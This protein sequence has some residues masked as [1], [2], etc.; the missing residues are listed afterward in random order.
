V[1][2]LSD[3]CPEAHI[4]AII[5]PKKSYRDS[6]AWNWLTSLTT[7]TRMSLA[8]YINN[9]NE[10][11]LQISDLYNKLISFSALYVS[12]ILPLSCFNY[13]QERQCKYNVILRRYRVTTVAVQKQHLITTYSE[14]VSVAWVIKHAKRMNC[15]LLSSV[16]CL[17]LPYFSTLSHKQHEIKKKRYWTKNVCFDILCKF[18][19]QH[20]SF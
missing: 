1:I 5:P 6:T 19:L 7:K 18:C 10:E 14:C 17:V 8:F 3:H 16:A 9:S 15:N 12:S 4:K 20:F 11:E 13:L 2:S